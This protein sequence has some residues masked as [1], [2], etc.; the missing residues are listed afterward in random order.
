MSHL[1]SIISQ[2]SSL[3]PISTCRL[4]QSR[5]LWL[6]VRLEHPAPWHRAPHHALATSYAPLVRTISA[7]DDA[8]ERAHEAS[9]AAARAQVASSYADGAE[10]DGAGGGTGRATRNSLRLHGSA[11]RGVYERYFA[12]GPQERAAVRFTALEV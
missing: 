7:F 11:V 10:G 4:Q 12:R 1:L 8:Q 6:L 3:I 9:I 2:H 5:S